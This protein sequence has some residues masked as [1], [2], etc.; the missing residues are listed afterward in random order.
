MIDRNPVKGVTRIFNSAVAP[1]EDGFVAVLRGEQVN[2]IPHIY[3]GYS[4]DAI[5]W[6]ID[7]NRIPFV[8][9]EGKPFMPGY[10][11]DPRLVKVEDTYYIMWCTDFYGAAIGLAKTQDFKTFVRMENPFIPFN[12]NAVL[13]PARSTAS[14]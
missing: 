8:D 14:T 12:R 4:K 13:F 9:E 7:E 3:M 5:H 2:G 11:Y 1:Y 6:T 10:A